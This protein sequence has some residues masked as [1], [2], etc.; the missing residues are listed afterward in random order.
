M[1]KSY[2][3]AL[4]A[5]L[6][7]AIMFTPLFSQSQVAKDGEPKTKL[8]QFQFQTG[9]VVIKG[10]SE[11]GKLNALGSVTVLAMEFT[12]AATGAKQQG[13]V[14]EVKE[15]GRLEVKDRSFIDY[16]EVDALLAGLDYILVASPSVTQ[17]SSFEA[18]YR[19]KGNFAV[20]TFSSGYSGIGASIQCGYLRP[21]SAY[22]SL[23]QLHKFRALVAEAKLRLD[24]T[25]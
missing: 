14:I 12:D 22:L 1:T 15:D 20:S 21:A 3:I 25:Q 7:Q 8:E 13:V 6:A 2:R 11:I 10:Y 5:L 16:E 9:S 24:S 17:L 4:A 18:T 19:T 23:E